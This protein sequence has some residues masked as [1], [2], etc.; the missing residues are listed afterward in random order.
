MTT[1]TKR[2]RQ[3]GLGVSSL[4]LLGA[5]VL[6]SDVPARGQD[7]VQSRFTCSAG[8]RKGVET[9]GVDSLYKDGGAGFDLATAPQRITGGACSSDKPFFFSIAAVDGDYQVT[10]TLG[11][12][13]A[14]RTTVKAESRRLM[15]D[16][17]VLKAGRS[18][19]VVF[20]VN[21][22]TA[23]IAG[24]PAGADTVRLKPREIGIL[25]WDNKLTLEFNGENPSVRAISIRKVDDVPTV[26]IAGD[27]TVVDQDK[28]PWAAWGQM[29]PEFFGPE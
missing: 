10:L 16:K 20:N 5:V 18:Q 26:Y 23:K 14:S 29:L 17:L 15:V 6:L 13:Q 1:Q 3:N 12:P 22:R 25:E 2:L 21:V 19:E 27:S 28:E 8:H 11:G 4:L 7:A 24:A 9:L